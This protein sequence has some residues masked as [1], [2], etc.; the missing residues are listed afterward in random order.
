[1]KNEQP[2]IAVNP[3]DSFSFSCPHPQEADRHI[4][5]TSTNGMAAASIEWK[6]AHSNGKFDVIRASDQFIVRAGRVQIDTPHTHQIIADG[7]T[8]FTFIPNIPP[9][10]FASDAVDQPPGCVRIAK[11]RTLPKLYSEPVAWDVINLL[12][13]NDWLKDFASEIGRDRSFGASLTGETGAPERY[14]YLNNNLR[15][16]GLA[17]L[18]DHISGSPRLAYRAAKGLELLCETLHAMQAQ[19]LVTLRPNTTLSMAD[20]QRVVDARRLIEE[21]FAEPLTLGSISLKCGLNREKLTR[22]F[23][24]LFNTTVFDA[25][26]EER[27]LNAAAMLRGTNSSVSTIAYQSGYLNN[28]SFTRAFGRRFGVSPTDYR[29]GAD[30]MPAPAGIAD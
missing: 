7:W 3:N 4:D 26:G 15:S 12:M 1:M 25:L 14:Y 17:A 9:R 23:R 21:H 13:R 28:A 16:I 11:S 27:L 18:S 6:H 8:V 24:E 30:A 19:E 5:I 20:A 29:R 2:T 22:G 10:G